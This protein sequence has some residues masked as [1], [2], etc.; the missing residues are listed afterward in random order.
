MADAVHPDPRQGIG[1]KGPDRPYACGEVSRRAN[2]E[3]ETLRERCRGPDLLY[4]RP[5][6]P[7]GGRPA[8]LPRRPTSTITTTEVQRFAKAVAGSMVA[9]ATIGRSGVPLLD[10]HGPRP[11][12]QSTRGG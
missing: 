10:S 6:L 4:R 3:P 9:T 12:V 5:N 7:F 8:G 1:R 2:A 11:Y